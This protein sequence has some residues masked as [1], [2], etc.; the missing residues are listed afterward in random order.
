MTK[1]ALNT[2]TLSTS[3]SVVILFL[4]PEDYY[5]CSIYLHCHTKSRFIC[6]KMVEWR[7]KS[8]SKFRVGEK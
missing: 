4:L 8:S 5:L 2:V 7:K 1:N 3:P 6:M